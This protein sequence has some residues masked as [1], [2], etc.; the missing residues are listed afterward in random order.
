MWYSTL[1]QYS[2]L[3][4][5]SDGNHDDSEANYDN[6]VDCNREH[7]DKNDDSDDTIEDR[8]VPVTPQEK[9]DEQLCALIHRR[10]DDFLIK[11]IV[12][13]EHDEVN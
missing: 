8:N 10:P 9:H 4:Y 2:E 3:G 6:N 11:D 7:D 5:I 13:S 1:T 12:N